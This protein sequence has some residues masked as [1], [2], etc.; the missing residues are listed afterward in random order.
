[1]TL[2]DLVINL[3]A[4]TATLTRDFNKAHGQAEKFAHDVGSALASIG[5]GVGLGELANGFK[6]MIDSEDQIGRVAKTMGMTTEQV[7]GLAFAIKG[8]DIPL[9]SVTRSMGMFD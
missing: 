8:F 4:E 9:E 1:M 5:V 3:H 7:S 6:E 2:A